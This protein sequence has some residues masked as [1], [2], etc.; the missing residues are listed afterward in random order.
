[1]YIVSVLSNIEQ[2]QLSKMDLST[3]RITL[4]TQ[5]THRSPSAKDGEGMQTL[6][7][8]TNLFPTYK[9]KKHSSNT[10]QNKYS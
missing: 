2:N 9:T 5:Y 1:M 3:M 4:R 7:L 6:S 8:W 10:A